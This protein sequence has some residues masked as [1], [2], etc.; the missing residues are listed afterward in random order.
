MEGI[1]RWVSNIV[2]Y[3]IFVTIITNL[4]PAGKYEKYLR[5]FAGCILIL[6]VLQPLTGGLRL[7]EKSMQFSGPSPLRM[8]RA[9]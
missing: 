7:D 1:Y 8:K 2:Y 5:L 4:L 3:L 6:L 9:N